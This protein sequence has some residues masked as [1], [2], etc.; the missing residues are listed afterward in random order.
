MLDGIK[1]QQQTSLIQHSQHSVG[2]TRR[3][4]MYMCAVSHWDQTDV[5]SLVIDGHRHRR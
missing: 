3:L 4:Y 2:C 1:N 5:T